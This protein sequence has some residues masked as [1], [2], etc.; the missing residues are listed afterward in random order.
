MMKSIKYTAALA[1][2]II[3]ATPAIAEDGF[4]LGGGLSYTTSKGTNTTVLSLDTEDAFASGV[5]IGGYR[6]QVGNHFWATELQLEFPTSNDFDIDFAGG[7]FGCSPAITPY[8][9]ELDTVVRLRG[10]YG[11][12]I[13]EGLELYGTG[14]LV[15]VSGEAATSPLTTGSFSSI[16]LSLGLGVQKTISQSW[17]VRGEINHD[18]ASRAISD[19]NAV[20]GCC[21]Y[22]I[23][24]TSLQLSILKSF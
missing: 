8:V 10:V 2:L 9:C 23:R 15:Y 14:G 19:T 22:N 20:A 16:G 21:D 6:K 17:K 13:A 12:E 24:Q 4:Y 3:A 5:L 18:I 7:T 11:G 1:S